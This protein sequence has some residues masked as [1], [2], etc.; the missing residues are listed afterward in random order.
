MEWITESQSHFIAEPLRFGRDSWRSASAT[1]CS[2]QGPL[3]QVAQDRVQLCSGKLQGWKFDNL[4]GQPAPL[5]DHLGS[6][7]AFYYF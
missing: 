1:P 2:E 5:F 7:K 6:E 3:E 4:S